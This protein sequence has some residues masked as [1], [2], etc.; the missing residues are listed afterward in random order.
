MVTGSA[1]TIRPL[2]YWFGEKSLF[3][4]IKLLSTRPTFYA[5]RK[6]PHHSTAQTPIWPRQHHGLEKLTLYSGDSKCSSYS[7]KF[8]GFSEHFENIPNFWCSDRGMW[9]V[10]WFGR[11]AG[12]PFY[13]PLLRSC[14]D[15]CSHFNHFCAQWASQQPRAIHINSSHCYR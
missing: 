4:I 11:L 10:E 12:E 15:S 7:M 13:S 8:L 5:N 1:Y 6:R 14:L 9:A 3:K 2:N